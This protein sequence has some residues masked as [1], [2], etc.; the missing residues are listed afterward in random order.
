MIKIGKLVSRFGRFL[1]VPSAVPKKANQFLWFRGLVLV[2]GLASAL[3]QAAPNVRVEGVLDR[4][5]AV[6]GQEFTYTVSVIS[7]ESVNPEDP[8]IPELDG[9]RVVNSSTSS[10]TSSNMSVG[11][12]G[13]QIETTQR[14]DYGF[15]MIPLR[16]GTL[17]LPPFSVRINGQLLKTKPVSLTVVEN[18]GGLAQGGPPPTINPGAPAIEDVLDDPDALFR[19]LL[20]RRL[21][22]PPEHNDLPSNPNEVLFIQTEVDK[23]EVYE[24]EQVTANWYILVRGNLLSL[25]RTKFPD[26]KGFWKEIIEEVPA[27][28]FSQE[29]INGQ[30][31]RRALL[32]SHALFPIKAGTAK[33]DEYRI[34]GRVQVPT[35]A[36]GFGKDYAFTRASDQVPIKVLPL[37]QE[38]KPKDFTG[39]VGLFQVNAQLDNNVVPAHQPMTL[40]IRFEGSGNAKMIEMPPIDWPPGLEMVEVKSESRFFKNGQSF[41]QFEFILIP[42]QAGDL[43]VPPISVSLFNPENKQYYT[44]TLENVVLKVI[45]DGSGGKNIPSARLADKKP[46]VPVELRLPDPILE[47]EATAGIGAFVASSANRAG[48]LFFLYAISFVWL[49]VRAFSVFSGREQKKDLVKLLQRRLKKAEA[50]AGRSDFRA[51]GVE[52]INLFA[53][54]LG[55]LTGQGGS[56][57]EIEKMLELGPP[58]LRRQFGPE[59]LTQLQDF[60]TLAFAPEELLKSAKSSGELNQKVAA[61]R[62]LLQAAILSAKPSENG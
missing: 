36:F 47:Q 3:A 13:W 31:Y 18:A 48:V 49:G 41:K 14:Y 34:K 35:S 5:Q 11:P 25:D 42:R 9:L 16:K 30:V 40:K 1:K 57:R 22:A 24:G 17:T 38:G 53:E 45:D 6:L 4:R 50:A 62:K 26:L 59:I 28:Q 27:L 10:S 58:S 61:A 20:Q 52:M 2:L 37:P 39:A 21:G 60:Q 55:E 54:I 56:H 7:N 46:D 8:S 23:K 29:V 32:A 15:L 44:R 51:A 12:N 33:I 43:S 19:Q